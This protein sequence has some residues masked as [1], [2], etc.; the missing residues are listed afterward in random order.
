MLRNW[1]DSNL[2]VST[3]INNTDVNQDNAI[4]SILYAKINLPA[5]YFCHRQPS[6]K[7]FI[8]MWSHVNQWNIVLQI[9]LVFK[10]I[11]YGALL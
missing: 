7:K 9:S 2:S 3:F 4:F 8:I 10:D 1:K 5:K 6:L 11:L